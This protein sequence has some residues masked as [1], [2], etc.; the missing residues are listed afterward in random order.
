MSRTYRISAGLA[1]RPSRG[2]IRPGTGSRGG[3]GWG[4]VW[5]IVWCIVA[6][7][8]RS[9]PA[10]FDVLVGGIDCYAKGPSLADPEIVT[11][12]AITPKATPNN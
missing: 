12:C 1:A 8:V 10:R 3:V 2:W 5:L 11:P 4:A 9:Q 6:A 7:A